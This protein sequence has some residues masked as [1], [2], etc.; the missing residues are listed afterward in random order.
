MGP[1]HTYS[2]GERLLRLPRGV[3]H[4]ADADPFIAPARAGAVTVPVAATRSS[5]AQS[6]AAG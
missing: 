3:L 2:V 1:R 5:G 4:P 6:S